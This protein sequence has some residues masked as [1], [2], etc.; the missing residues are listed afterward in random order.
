MGHAHEVSRLLTLQVAAGLSN[1]HTYATAFK[2]LHRAGR[3]GMA[4]AA[5]D[6]ASGRDLGPIACSTLLHCATLE[7][8]LKLA[9]QLFDAMVAHQMKL[10]RYS[11]NF[12]AHLASLNGAFDDIVL[13][14]NMMK[15]AASAA[16]GGGAASCSPDSCTYSL[17]VRAAVASGRG[18]LLP[19]LWNEMVAARRAAERALGRLRPLAARVAAGG[20]GGEGGGEGWMSTEGPLWAGKGG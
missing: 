6:E 8:N 9:W 13:V 5:F 18:E 12:I 14:Y 3:L 1:E 10:N 15:D 7:R 11:Y 16:T 19:A 4:L 20:G 2:A 17:L